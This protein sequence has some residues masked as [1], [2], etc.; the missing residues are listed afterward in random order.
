MSSANGPANHKITYEWLATNQ[1]TIDPRVQRL[2]DPRKVQKIADN[3]DPAAVGTITV[4]QRDNGQR[5]ILN[6]QH[7]CAGADQS[8]YTGKIHCEVHHGLSVEDE[9]HYFLALNDQTMPSLL[10]KFLVRITEGDAVALDIEAILAS[11]GW[12]IA[13]GSSDACFAAVGAIERVYRTASKTLP[14]GEHADL[15][16]AVVWAVTSAWGH[17]VRAVNGYILEGLAKLFGRFGDAVNRPKLVK[18][19]Q[20]LTPAT[21]IGTAR[22][23]QAGQG[24]TIP[25]AVA[26]VLVGKHN[27]R[28]RT[29]LLPEWVWTR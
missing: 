22:T 5:V 26:K 15:T 16:D 17:D 29:N 6:G 1:L 20:S 14:D 11:H 23:L 9:A 21:L 4:S 3:F 25:A 10:A 27:N 7:R 24:G 12:K 13:P 19:M 8:G 18:E 28:L 2:R